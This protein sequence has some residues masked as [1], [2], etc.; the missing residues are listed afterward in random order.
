MSSRES[1]MS[2]IYGENRGGVGCVEAGE[3]VVKR[4]QV[5]E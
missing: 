3:Q 5:D 2:P 1:T 4:E